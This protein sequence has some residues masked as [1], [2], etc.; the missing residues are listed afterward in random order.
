MR[1]LV[2]AVVDEAS[3][4]YAGLVSGELD[5]AGVSPAMARLVADD[6]LLALET[7]PVLFS[8]VLAFNGTRPPFD[9]PLVRRATSLALDRPRIVD[10]AVAGYAFPASGALSPDVLPTHDPFAQPPR[11]VARAAAGALLDRAG[12]TARDAD[13]VRRR[14]DVRLAVELLTVGSGDLAVEQLVQDDLRRVGIDVRLRPVDLA[15]FLATVRAPARDFDVA[16]TGIPGDIALGH[17]RA[18][19]HST[20]AG[21]AL[22]YTGLHTPALDA[23]LDALA[24]TPPVTGDPQRNA[25]LQRLE[26]GFDA[27]MPVAWL[28]HARGVQGRRASLEGVRMDLRGELATVQQW[29]RRGTVR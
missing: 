26:R 9:E 2:V 20:Q 10:V 24:E 16:L 19:A 11:D 5:V 17:L 12:W 15:T 22:D 1:E 13:G 25:V 4:K 27:L 28:Y 7:P 18:L 14:G 29:R 23:A 21:G 3:T 8:T 6:P